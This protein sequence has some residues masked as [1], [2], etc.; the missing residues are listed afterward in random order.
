MAPYI[1]RAPGVITLGPFPPSFEERRFL[2]VS[3][4]RGKEL[5]WNALSN[6][7]GMLGV[8]SGLRSELTLGCWR[9]DLNAGLLTTTEL[10]LFFNS[11]VPCPPMHFATLGNSLARTF[12]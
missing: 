11:I 1:F 9:D 2:R 3:G 4:S 6:P 5:L 10:G 7:N 8:F 12:C